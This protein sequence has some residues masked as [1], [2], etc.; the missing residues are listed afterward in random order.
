[1][2]I[3]REVVSP[4]VFAY[5]KPGDNFGQREAVLETFSLGRTSIVHDGCRISILLDV[6]QLEMPPFC[7]FRFFRLTGQE[8]MDHEA[9]EFVGLD[10][11]WVQKGRMNIK[12]CS[13]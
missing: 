1:C 7:Q 13:T 11:L 6:S 12:I 9:I 4:A 5:G 3:S 8:E 10:K 2:L